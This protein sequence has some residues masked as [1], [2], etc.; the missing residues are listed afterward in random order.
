M[1]QYIR[2]SDFLSDCP[3]SSSLMPRPYLAHARRMGLVSQVLSPREQTAW[4]RRMEQRA[5]DRSNG[6]R[7]S[8][9]G[10]R[11]PGTIATVLGSHPKEADSLGPQL[12]SQALTPRKQTAW[13][14]S[15]G[16]RPSPQGSRQP[17]TV[18]TVLGSHP[19]EAE[20]LGPK[21]TLV[22]YTDSMTICAATL[23]SMRMLKRAANRVPTRV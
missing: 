20:S 23:C 17:G 12:R 7:L 22:L 9:Q 15:Y 5:R 14:C 6:P 21:L 2:C 11:E 18:A 19:K 13:G 16:P 4:G 1:V 8:L 10:S 3:L